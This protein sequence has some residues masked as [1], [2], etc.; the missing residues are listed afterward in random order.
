MHIQNNIFANRESEF[1][2]ASQ[3]VNVL[4]KNKLIQHHYNQTKQFCK[5]LVS[6]YNLC[7]KNDA[8]MKLLQALLQD[9]ERLLE[10]YIL[11]KYPWHKS[12][13]SINVQEKL[14][15]E[16][17]ADDINENDNVKKNKH[18]EANQDL[19]EPIKN[20]LKKYLLDITV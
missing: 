18:I 15:T 16:T 4:D 5:I 20:K 10:N 3:D 13:Q 17:N 6:I 19:H 14:S 9:V 8:C 12:E 2:L 11:D 1:K 7:D